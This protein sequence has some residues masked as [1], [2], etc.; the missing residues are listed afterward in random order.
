MLTASTWSATR[1]TP[2]GDL[3]RH[4]FTLLSRARTM[5]PQLASLLMAPDDAET[6]RLLGV[7]P[8]PT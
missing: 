1:T 5:V 6:Y 4:G 7:G 2:G 8:P 3:D